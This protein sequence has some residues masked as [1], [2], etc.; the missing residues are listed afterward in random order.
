M[1]YITLGKMVELAQPLK[2]TEYGQYLLNLAKQQA[3]K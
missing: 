2:K 1:G 3:G